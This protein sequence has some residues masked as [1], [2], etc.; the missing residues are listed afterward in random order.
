M[1]V[2]TFIVSQG[3]NTSN[4]YKGYGYQTEIQ[5]VFLLIAKVA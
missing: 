4:G 3:N 1:Y 2:K 5:F